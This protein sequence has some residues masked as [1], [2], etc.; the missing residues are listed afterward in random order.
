VIALTMAALLLVIADAAEGF[1]ATWRARDR[2]KTPRTT[3]P[4]TD[5]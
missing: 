1:R 5:D 2:R 3:T 4:R